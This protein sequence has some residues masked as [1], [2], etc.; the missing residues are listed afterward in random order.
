SR[1]AT[2]AETFDRFAES[3][4]SLCATFDGLDGDAWATIA[5]APCGHVPLNIVAHH[6]LWDALIH[7][8]DVVLPLG[9]TPIEE[10]D[11]IV[12]SL[13]YCAA[14]GPVI[15]ATHGSRRRGTLALIV[16]DPDITIVVE[17]G[18]STHVHDGLVPAG[19]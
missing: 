2:P 19:A 14:L 10:P 6:A 1:S 13:R 17:A 7:E 3:N 18:G 5:E 16:A 8:R 15:A 4:A 9:M 12:S 11:E